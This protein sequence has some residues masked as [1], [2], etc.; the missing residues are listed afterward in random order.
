ML[1]KFYGW[2]GKRQV[3]VVIAV[4][5][6]LILTAVYLAFFKKNEA[7][8][9]ATAS[10][11]VVEVKSVKNINFE[12]SFTSVGVVEAISEATL[13]TEAGGRITSV[14]TEIGK[15]VRAGGVIATIESA[16]ERASVLQAQGAY[17]AAL[18]GSASG[19]VSVSGAEIALS[20]AQKA[21]ITTHQNAF[22]GLDT[23]LHST[24]D[25]YFSINNGIASGIKLDA[26]GK[27][28]ALNAERTRLE[29]LFTAWSQAK[30]AL[31]QTSIKTEL[32]T[33]Y[34][35][36]K[37]VERFVEQLSLLAQDQ[38]TSPTYTQT[39]KDIDI[40]NI[41]SARLSLSGVLSQ[42]EA[43]QNQITGSE[44]ALEQA[45]LAGA[46][47]LPS[48]SNA[49]IKI[50]LGSLRAAQ[51]QYEKTVV[52][53]PITGVVNALY[54]KTGEYVSPSQP[55]AVVANNNGL[56]VTTSVSEGDSA[57]IAIGDSVSIGGV[58]TGTITAIAGAIDPT[59]GKVAVK[60]SI[61]DA[62]DISN[63]STVSVSF[64]QSAEKVTETITIPL[65]AIKMTGSGPIAFEVVEGKLKA[66]TLTLGEISGDSVVV[67]QG[68]TLDT[69][70]VVDAR[71][72]KEDAEVEVTTN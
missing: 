59:T 56:Q 6:V 7:E 50:A 23:A 47:G 2:Y 64:T 20:S 38:D 69:Q 42:I 14:N 24:I 1:Q 72:L 60:I 71:G 66:I 44:K 67:T 9:V 32:Q 22:I 19:E 68:L 54:L 26:Q 46:K 12:N 62:S 30:N 43:A 70:I 5:C 18:A 25:D 57:F 37:A 61:D 28:V 10:K 17:E 40:T 11:E 33:A 31:T 45:R 55:A 63:G 29:G 15:T 4:L 34:A 27:A 13:Q 58:K 65:S 21:G 8:P 48:A 49:Q 51:A 16:S 36:T 3:Q 35:T 52:R 41:N 39:Q 53:S